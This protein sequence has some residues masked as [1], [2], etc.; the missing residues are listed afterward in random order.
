MYHRPDW[1]RNISHSY[2][3]PTDKIALQAKIRAK[4]NLLK[5]YRVKKPHGKIER[6]GLKRVRKMSKAR[7]KKCYGMSPNAAEI[8]LDMV[9]K[10]LTFHASNSDATLP[11]EQFLIFIKWITSLMDFKD[12][13]EHEG[14][15]ENTAKNIVVKVLAHIS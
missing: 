12:V 1:L 13:A 11:E 8:F 5:K 7:F 4:A 3:L 2:K 6:L 10:R 14:V 15:A 9:S